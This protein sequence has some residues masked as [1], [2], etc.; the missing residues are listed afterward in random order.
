[1][2]DAGTSIMIATPAYTGCTAGY[3]NSL[4]ATKDALQSDGHK[5]KS[6]IMPGVAIISMARNEIGRHFQLSGYEYIFSVDSDLMWSVET[7]RRMLAYAR[8]TKAEFLC[9]VQPI[10][11]L[12]LEEIE[13]AAK[14]GDP[15]AVKLGRRYSARM[16]GEIEG[17]GRM[18]INSEG[19]GKIDTAGVAFALI[20]RNVFDKLSKAHPQLRYRAPDKTAGYALFDPFVRDEFAYAE[21]MAFCRRHRDLGGDIELLVDAPLVH[22]G[23]YQVT[24]NFV[25][26][27][28]MKKEAA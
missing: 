6:F 19:F 9:G 4:L 5:V 16:L 24:G 14:I 10:R 28:L 18:E 21:D 15:N 2:S 3:I 12:F 13:H 1:M 23:P 26:Q 27:L 25:D 8:K 11:H 7:I 22:E 17:N 20:H